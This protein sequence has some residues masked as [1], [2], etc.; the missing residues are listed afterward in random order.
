[1]EYSRGFLDVRRDRIF[2]HTAFRPGPWLGDLGRG[3]PQESQLAVTSA[4]YSPAG[5]EARAQ[6]CVRL[7]NQSL[8]RMV[9]I[10]LLRLRQ[11]YLAIAERLR[12]HGQGALS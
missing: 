10:E 9:Q 5:Y 6:E 4:S 12:R 8:D 1:M 2:C 3:A 7:A 11:T